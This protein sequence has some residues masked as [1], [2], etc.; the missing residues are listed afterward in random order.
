MESGCPFIQGD[1]GF[2]TGSSLEISS[3]AKIPLRLSFIYL[4]FCS[5]REQTKS[6]LLSTVHRHVTIRNPL[7]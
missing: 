7:N 4:Y 2:Q 1:L 3:W 5:Y 6:L